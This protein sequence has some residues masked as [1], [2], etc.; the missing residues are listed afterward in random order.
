MEHK[1]FE[2]IY[3]AIADYV[4]ANKL[5]VSAE[6]TEGLRVYK[7]YGTYIFFHAN[8]LANRLAELTPYVRLNT[9]V[10]NK[11][12]V[13]VIDA[14]N[15]VT[16]FNID[17]NF[18]KIIAPI[19]STGGL[20]L[21]PPEVELVDVYHRLYLPNLCKTWPA[22]REYEKAQW[23]LFMGQRSAIVERD[24]RGGLSNEHLEVVTMWLKSLEEY[25][26][27]GALGSRMMSG[28]TEP[29]SGAIQLIV[30][31]PKLAIASLKKYLS[32]FGHGAAM[33]TK[34]YELNLPTDYRIKKYVIS[35]VIKGSTYYVAN[36]FNSAAYELV[37]YIL[38]DGYKVGALTVLMR[39]LFI[40][41][42]FM[43][44]LRFFDMM[45]IAE[46]KK[47]IQ[48]TF[49]SIDHAH[50]L[51]SDS[52]ACDRPLYVGTYVDESIS[53]KQV[54]TIY[55]YYPAKHKIDHGHYRTIDMP[56]EH[57]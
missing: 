12:F 34:K 39:F 38:H 43:R 47:N 2:P 26:I 8:E 41:L 15:M 7:V 9:V 5:I 18:A 52:S 35:V 50:S 45:S 31:N 42:W 54:D 55:P 48:T 22:L 20:P 6:P 1:Q 3:A 19:G 24:V 23:T 33:V 44:I 13:L 28:S 30:P 10:R 53:K 36:F 29:V 40:D 25:V 56:A 21:V 17:P 46:Y 14:A 51:W 16:M 37:P 4:S 57:A 11:E 49:A 32:K 27:V